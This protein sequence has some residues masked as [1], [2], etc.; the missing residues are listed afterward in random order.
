MMDWFVVRTK[1]RQELRAVHH[2]DEQGFNVYCPQIPKYNGL[3][4]VVGRQALFPGYCFVQS[5]ELSIASIR[6]TPGV[7][8]LVS[9]GPQGTPAALGPTALEA[10]HAVEAFHC[11]KVSGLKPGGAVSLIEGPFKG[12]KGLY[13]KRLKDRVEVLLTLLGQQQRILVPSSQV[14]AG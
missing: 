7:I 4:E 3:K 5:G 6:S 8:G 1:A 11:D 9:F 14:I 10:I 13:S 2:M 12:F